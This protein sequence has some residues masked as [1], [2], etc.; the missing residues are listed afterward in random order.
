MAVS[1]TTLT[2]AKVKK[3]SSLGM[4]WRRFLSRKWAVA[5]GIFILLEIMIAIFAPGHRPL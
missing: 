2:P 1:A 4:A 3:S 5:A